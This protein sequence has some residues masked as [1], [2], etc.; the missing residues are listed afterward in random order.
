MDDLMNLLLPPS[1]VVESELAV[2]D[3]ADDDFLIGRADPAARLDAHAV[4]EELPAERLR[5]LDRVDA[6]G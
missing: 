4:D 1:C 5:H 2:D 6:V 3:A